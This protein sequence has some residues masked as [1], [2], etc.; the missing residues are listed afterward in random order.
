MFVVS[1]PYGIFNKTSQKTNFLKKKK[2]YKQ[3]TVYF[4]Q[5]SSI[6][7]FHMEA[8]KEQLNT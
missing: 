3:K 1:V 4:L 8:E 7:I 6:K 2:T 5:I